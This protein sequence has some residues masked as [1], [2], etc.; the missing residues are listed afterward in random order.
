MLTI[1]LHWK[2]GPRVSWRTKSHRYTIGVKRERWI[3]AA[4]RDMMRS[5]RYLAELDA[6]ASLAQLTNRFRE[7]RV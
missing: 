4:Q 1:T 3:S 7:D 5:D 2:G 6:A